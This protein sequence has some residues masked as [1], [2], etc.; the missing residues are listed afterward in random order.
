MKQFE[1]SVQL[2]VKCQCSHTNRK[3]RRS[4][5]WMSKSNKHKRSIKVLTG[6]FCWLVQSAFLTI[7]SQQE[8]RQNST[9]ML[10]QMYV[11]ISRRFRRCR[12]CSVTS[13]DSR[14]SAVTSN[15]CR[16]W[17]CSTT[18]TRA[19]TNSPRNTK[20]TRCSR[21]FC[22]QLSHPFEILRFLNRI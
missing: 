21:N 10:Y 20:S 3:K 16:W 6:L 9:F 17:T 18:C 11:M 14:P 5:R 1:I 22:L 7:D 19:S 2:S 8:C 4:N 12:S 15:R 13:W